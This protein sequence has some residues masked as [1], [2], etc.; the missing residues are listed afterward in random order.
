[1]Y[2]QDH[3]LLFS[4]FL[5]IKNIFINIFKNSEMNKDGGMLAQHWATFDAIG[6]ALGR[7]SVLQGNPQ[8]LTFTHPL[9][10][11]PFEVPW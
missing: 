11:V 9:T 3:D 8:S 6:S 5:D 10:L 4:I 1:M 7:Q 2:A